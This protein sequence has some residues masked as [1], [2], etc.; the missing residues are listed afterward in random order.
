MP[1]MILYLHGFNSAPASRK[2]QAL[3]AYLESHGLPHRFCCPALPHRPAEAVA[4]IAAAIGRCGQP[5]LVGSSLG[6]FYATHFAERHNLRAVLINPAITPHV[7]LKSYL[8]RQQNLYTGASYSL[9][10]A[11]LEGWRALAVG[12]VDPERYLLLLETGD[13]LLDWREAAR[14][15]EGARTVIRDGGDHTLQS[16]GEHLPR[17]LAFAGLTPRA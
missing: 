6:G 11:D 4:V 5:T 10:P 2:A 17:I 3:Q 14:K 8:G 13:E 7:G 12:R 1:A 15:Y 9:T 16:F